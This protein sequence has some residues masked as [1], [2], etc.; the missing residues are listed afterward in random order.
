MVKLLKKMTGQ[1]GG[2]VINIKVF[3]RGIIEVIIKY[4]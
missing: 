2:W 4:L 1:Y 3:Y